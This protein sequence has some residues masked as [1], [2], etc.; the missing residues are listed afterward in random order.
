MYY[1]LYESEMRHRELR[2]VKQDTRAETT[3]Q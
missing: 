3:N 2:H 1:V